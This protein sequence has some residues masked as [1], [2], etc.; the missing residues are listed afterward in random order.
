MPSE[1]RFSS[2]EKNL[3]AY[4]CPICQPVPGSLLCTYPYLA[5][6]SLTQFNR[7][8]TMLYT[9]YPVLPQKALAEFQNH[10]K[11]TD[12][13]HAMMLFHGGFR[14]HERKRDVLDAL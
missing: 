14:L 6:L 5:L 9:V 10:S 13:H 2:A 1:Q 8:Y 4:T 12:Q 3:C 11:S 7:V